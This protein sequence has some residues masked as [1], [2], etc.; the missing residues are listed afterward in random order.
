M[1]RTR[2]VVRLDKHSQAQPGM[3]DRPL[4]PDRLS[5]NR[6]HCSASL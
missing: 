2:R 4:E 6:H 3:G 5:V 1:R